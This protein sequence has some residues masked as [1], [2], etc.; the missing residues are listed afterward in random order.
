MYSNALFSG[1][2]FSFSALFALVTLAQATTATTITP[3]EVRAIAKEAYVYGYPLVDNYRVQYAYFVDSKDAEYKAP[4]NQLTNIS[5]VFTPEDKAIQTPNSDTP[6]SFVGLDLRAEPMVLT[7]PAIP[8]ERYFSVQLIDMYT[9][10]FD[11]LGSRA[12][13]N[14]GGSFLIAG[15]RWHGAVPKGITK[16]IRCETEIAMATYRTQLFNPA[17]LE[18]VKKIQSQY[19][20]QSLSSFLGI[21]APK[22]APAIAFIKPL[23]LEAQKSSPAF[24]NQLNFTLQFCPTVP[25][26][27]ALRKRFSRIGIAPGKNFDASALSADLQAAISAG[28]AEA[29][30]DLAGVK[31]GVEAGKVSSGDAFGTREYLKN[32]Y[33]YRMAGAVLGIYGNSKQEAMYPAYY[34]DSNGQKLDASFNRYTLRFAKGQLPPVNSFW[35]LTMYEQPASLLVANPFN[36]YLINSPMLPS[37][38]PDQDGGITLYIQHDSPGKDHEANWLPAPK[39]PFSVIMRLYWPKADALDGKWKEPSIQQTIP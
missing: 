27:T 18:N 31:K 34:V 35:S 2:G 26:E 15:P 36:R 23:T 24:F 3:A 33:L 32:N 37:L 28:M 1:L 38:I 29:W 17:D 9:H 4:W 16:V 22:A 7:V 39:G 8:K 19:R 13:G 14:G 5:R 21:P 6:Y 20:V 25:S 12:T 10:N 11:Y 30:L